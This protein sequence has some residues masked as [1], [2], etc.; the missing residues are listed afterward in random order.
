MTTPAEPK[1]K[2]KTVKVN[3]VTLGKK[4]PNAPGAVF[5]YTP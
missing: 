2:A 3:A 1:G 4:S 5:T